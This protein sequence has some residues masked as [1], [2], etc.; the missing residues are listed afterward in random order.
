MLVKKDILTCGDVVGVPAHRASP[1]PRAGRPDAPAAAARGL[2]M[3]V[4][5]AVAPDRRRG[6]VARPRPCGWCP[7]G[8]RARIRGLGRKRRRGGLPLPWRVG[9]GQ[10]AWL[11]E[12]IGIRPCG[13]GVHGAGVADAGELRSWYGLC[14]YVPSPPLADGWMP[15]CTVYYVLRGGCARA[16]KQVVTLEAG[17]VLATRQAS[18]KKHRHI[19]VAGFVCRVVAANGVEARVSS[20]AGCGEAARRIETLHVAPGVESSTSDNLRHLPIGSFGLGIVESPWGR[21]ETDESAAAWSLPRSSQAGALRD[22]KKEPSIPQPHTD[23]KHGQAGRGH[24]A[25]RQ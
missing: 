14:I 16:S 8:A 17:R 11:R 7:G 13:R 20:G 15:V 5:A 23:R 3:G 18:Q 24:A 2:R 25:P 4:P 22:G 9:F 10:G 1:Q 6:P 19:V 21:I 12:Q